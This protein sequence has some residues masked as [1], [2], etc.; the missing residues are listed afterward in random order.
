M[1][2]IPPSHRD[3]A[4]I[5]TSGALQKV[6]HLL[7]ASPARCQELTPAPHARVSAAHAC[8]HRACEGLHAPLEPQ[9]LPSHAA[10]SRSHHDFSRASST[11]LLLLFRVL[12][13]AQPPDQLSTGVSYAQRPG[14]RARMRSIVRSGQQRVAQQFLQRTLSIASQ[15]SASAF[16]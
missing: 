13:A 9:P 14:Q 4:W 3:I 10:S 1:R 12:A 7:G 15:S 16:R 6:M 8:C 11:D 2:C 5:N